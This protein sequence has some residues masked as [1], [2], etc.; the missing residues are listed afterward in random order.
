MEYKYICEKCKLYTNA[1]STYD[2]HLLSG[3][4]INGKRATRSNKKLIEKCENCDYTTKNITNMRLHILNNHATKEERKEKLKY[5]CELCDYGTFG[6]SL[7]EKHKNSPKHK[8]IES[9]AK[10]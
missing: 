6:E 7:Y 8:L 4:H 2:K 9:Y 10:K 5:Y 1:K 3:I